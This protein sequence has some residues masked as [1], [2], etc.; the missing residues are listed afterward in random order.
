MKGAGWL[1]LQWG[2]VTII[3]GTRLVKLRQRGLGGARPSP[4]SPQR[5]SHEVAVKLYFVGQIALRL[6]GAG[7]AEPTSPRAPVGVEGEESRSGPTAAARHAAPGRRMGGGR[8]AGPVV[9]VVVVAVKAGRWRL[10]PTALAAEHTD[11]GRAGSTDVP[12]YYD[13]DSWPANENVYSDRVRR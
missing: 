3:M 13:T 1:R 8:A 6:N 12:R 2:S 4:G 9:A 7:G 11:G 10:G 5:W